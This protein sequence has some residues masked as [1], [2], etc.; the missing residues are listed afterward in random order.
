MEKKL[1]EIEERRKSEQQEMQIAYDQ[2]LADH[3]R[4]END[5]EEV[6]RSRDRIVESHRAVVAC[7]TEVLHQYDDEVTGLYSLILELL[8]IKQWFLTDG[9]AWFVKLVHQ[10]PELE[11][12]VADLVNCVNAIGINDGIKQ[13]FQAAKATDKQVTKVIGY[14][15]GAKDAL[16]AA[17]AAFDNFHISVLHKALDLLNEPLSVIKEKSKLPIIKDD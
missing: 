7:T 16:D 4:L 12:V 13:G 2:F 1:V 5:N 8:L 11:N 3:V 14:D 9:V 6:E 15:E 10:S 17:I